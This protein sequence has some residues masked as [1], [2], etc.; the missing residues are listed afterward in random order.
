MAKAIYTDKITR[1]LVGSIVYMALP[2]KG[3]RKTFFFVNFTDGEC[4]VCESI[5]KVYE[6]LNIKRMGQEIPCNF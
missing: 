6:A 2:V 4:A 1:D 3:I 5:K